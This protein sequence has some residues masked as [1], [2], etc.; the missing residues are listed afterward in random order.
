MKPV[1]GF[2]QAFVSVSD[3]SGQSWGMPRQIT[4]GRSLNL[5]D[6]GSS[7]NAAYVALLR[8]EV[9]FISSL[10]HGITW[11]QVRL[12]SATDGYDKW[13]PQVACDDSGNAYYCWQDEK[14]GTINGFT[15]TL[16][17]RKSGDYGLS[18]AS[19]K[20]LSQLPSVNRS[21]IAVANKSVHIVWADERGAGGSGVYYVG[22]T[23]RGISWCPEMKI[24]DWLISGGGDASVGAFDSTVYVVWGADHRIFFRSG[25]VQNTTSVS[26]T[27]R[28]PTAFKVLRAYP[29]PFNNLTN[30]EFQIPEAGEIAFDVFDV[31]GRKCLP[32][33]SG[34]YSAGTHRQSL[35]GSGL[36]SGFYYVTVHFKRKRE[37]LPIILIK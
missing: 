33:E 24:S 3:D 11:S 1:S 21:A 35:D 7:A 18:W 25:K 2:W 32:T 14:Y 29:N 23:D 6:L 4:N 9:G 36:S 19:E 8:D 10:D 20:R 15:G 13:D 27:D 26:E 28:L 16:L 12:L 30:V 31:L 17:L 37:A 22:S 34:S 5:E